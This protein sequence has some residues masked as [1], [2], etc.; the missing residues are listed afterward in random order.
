MKKVNFVRR[1]IFTL[2]I[3]TLI[4]SSC[5]DDGVDNPNQG[6]P[7]GEAMRAKIQENLAEATQ[8][9]T[10]DASTGGSIVGE[11]GA[12]LWFS[13]NLLIDAAGDSVKGD[14]TIDLIEIRGKAAMLLM[15][16]PTM[17]KNEAGGLEAL[18]SHGEFFVNAK[19]GDEQLF[20]RPGSGFT[21]AV[22]V[23]E[24]DS[25]MNLFRNDNEC[26]EA[27]CDVVWKEAGKGAVDNRLEMGQNQQ[28][29]NTY[30]AFVN[31]FGW[32]NI[33]RWYSDPRPKTTIYVDVPA[34]Y[35]DTNCAVYLS[36]DGE[37]TA[38]ANF[39]TYNA[40]D[41]L[42][43]EH[44]GLIPIGLEVH[45]I[46]VSVVD[47]EWNYAIQ[48]ATIADNHIEIVEELHPT[49]EAALVTLINGLP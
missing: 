1:I 27:D 21:L 2:G 18:K 20:L 32:T 28:G 44:Y 11:D 39:D 47:G 17:G 23:G 5:K 41:E 13:G 35:D 3:S 43:S 6:L 16:K 37:P 25:A 45:F 38:L 34:G 29:V 48:G 12:E 14:V 4:L 19:K 9:F 46:V 26:L 49:T 22:P 31:Q 8:S 10:L 7:D 40:T 30:Y 36:Y 33:D 15:D 24:L 42:F